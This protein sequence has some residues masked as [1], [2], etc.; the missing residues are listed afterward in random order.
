MP[1]VIAPAESKLTAD[2]IATAEA[3]VAARLDMDT[4]AQTDRAESGSVGSSGLIPLRYICTGNINLT[5]GGA[6]AAGV[7]TNPRTLDV[8]QLV[9]R[10]YGN[11]WGS[12]Y[13]STPYA[14]QYTSGWTA[15]TLP[16]QI[17][18]AVLHVAAQ[19]AAAAETAGIKSETLGPRSVTYVDT[20]S[21][22]T[23]MGDALNLLRPWLAVRF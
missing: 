18:Q 1:L 4:L 15:D 22:G 3:L 5:L 20:A 7:L 2:Q 21:T 9:N 19:G 8:R 14:V 17:R 23:L 6:P 11:P 16:E 10:S 12:G 13:V